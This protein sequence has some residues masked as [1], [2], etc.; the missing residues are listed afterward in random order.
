MFGGPHNVAVSLSGVAR[1]AVLCS[2]FAFD[3]AA[4]PAAGETA[5][6]SATHMPNWVLASGTTDATPFGL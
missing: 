6:Q 1:L 2:V 5:G 4:W 3:A